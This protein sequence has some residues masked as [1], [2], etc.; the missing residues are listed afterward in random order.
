MMDFNYQGRHSLFE[1][2]EHKCSIPTLKT[3][4]Y[5]QTVVH[6]GRETFDQHIG[7]DIASVVEGMSNMMKK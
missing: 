3:G 4:T 7:E 6:L 2:G 5:I 1:L